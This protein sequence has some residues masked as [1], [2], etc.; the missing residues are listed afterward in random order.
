MAEPAKNLTPKD[1]QGKVGD[2]I[3]FEKI[4]KEKAKKIDAPEK[5][6]LNVKNK[7][8]I[9]S[10][11]KDS[12]TPDDLDINSDDLEN[13]EDEE[14]ANDKGELID[15]EQARA[16]A[17]KETVP[18]DVNNEEPNPE[19]NG[20]LVDFPTNEPEINEE[21]TNNLVDFN[22][23]KKARANKTAKA[24]KNKTKEPKQSEKE[25]DKEEPQ[26]TKENAEPKAKE[27]ADEIDNE[28]A[29]EKPAGENKEQPEE[30][31]ENENDEK[32]TE[33]QNENQK[34]KKGEEKNKENEPEENLGKEKEPAKEEMLKAGQNEPKEDD[35]TE[36]KPEEESNEE[37]KN[38]DPNNSE[39]EPQLNQK[40]TADKIDDEIN[41]EKEENRPE[42][43]P[44]QPQKP[45]NTVAEPEKNTA[46]N[47]TYD[48]QGNYQPATDNNENGN[49]EPTT[50]AKTGGPKKESEIAGQMQSDRSKNQIKKLKREKKKVDAEIA[51][52]DPKAALGQTAKLLMSPAFSALKYIPIVGPTVCAI[53]DGVGQAQNLKDDKLEE[54]LKI[55][56]IVLELLKTLKIM[57][58]VVDGVKFSANLIGETIETIII[59]I[60]LLIISPAFVLFFTVTGMGE[61]ASKLKP[62]I[63]DVQNMVKDLEKKVK[64]AK[65]KKR[66]R[67]LDKMIKKE[68][69]ATPNDQEN[70]GG[71]NKN[72]NITDINSYRQNNTTQAGSTPKQV[73]KAA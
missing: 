8:E 3:D 38:K 73:K 51:M 12:I 34:S 61:L 36:N 9:A 58:G 47:P 54:L 28:N 33:N 71:K 68:E 25:S 18:T 2:V 15:L 56:K 13:F 20:E 44:K 72:N 22:K 52:N 42:K 1:N 4:V 70:R 14:L 19:N 16:Q 45:D 29:E 66:S 17:D 5:I 55:M 6:K 37:E 59:P 64:A 46:D 63:K 30:P 35:K 24:E 27:I 53:A 65:L 69:R 49:G 50:P 43:K 32:I 23:A 26:E 60:L 57:V 39:A 21:R 7:E 31:E 67:L 62:I 48:S 40:Q 10:A 41:K 11:V